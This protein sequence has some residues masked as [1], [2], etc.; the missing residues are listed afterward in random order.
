MNRFNHTS[1]GKGGGGLTLLQLTIRRCE[2]VVLSKFLDAFFVLSLCF[3][4]F[5]VRK[6][7]FVIGL[8]RCFPFSL[9]SITKL[10]PKINHIYA[11]NR[12]AYEDRTNCFMYIHDM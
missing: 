2:T 1:L 7:A 11:R 10:V 4:E 3:F 5:S 9:N 12:M 6:G 8:S